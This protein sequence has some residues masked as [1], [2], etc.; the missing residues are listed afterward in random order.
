MSRETVAASKTLQEVNVGKNTEGQTKEVGEFEHDRDA[1][2]LPD[3]STFALPSKHNHYKPLSQTTTQSVNPLP[4]STA[5]TMSTS[6]LKKAKSMA[7]DLVKKVAGALK[8]SNEYVLN[9]DHQRTF[10]DTCRT[11]ATRT[12]SPRTRQPAARPWSRQPSPSALPQRSAMQRS[13]PSSH[14]PR[15]PRNV[16]LSTELVCN[17]QRGVV[18]GCKSAKVQ[19]VGRDIKTWSGL[20]ACTMIRTSGANTEP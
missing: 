16:S 17:M 10:P 2:K 20:T 12:T 8:P 1:N 18:G 6:F 15:L 7:K 13:A 9:E 11:A 3:A 4:A 14:A 19:E 5:P